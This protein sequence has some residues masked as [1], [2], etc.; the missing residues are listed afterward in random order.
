[1]SVFDYLLQGYSRCIPILYAMNYRIPISEDYDDK[2]GQIMS[3]KAITSNLHFYYILIFKGNRDVRMDRSQD[4]AALQQISRIGGAEQTQTQ[5][6]SRREI[7][8]QGDDPVT[9]FVRLKAYAN[10]QY[11][12]TEFKAKFSSNA[13]N[14]WDFDPLRKALA[15]ARFTELLSK[16][17]KQYS[18]EYIE[19]M[20]V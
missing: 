4:T 12:V 9:K 20:K 19:I 14:L 2:I 7:F 1:M 6:Q 17:E 18:E 11:L 5:R 3:M 10:P 15:I 16:Y 13:D 8:Y